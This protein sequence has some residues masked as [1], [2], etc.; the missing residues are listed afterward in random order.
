MF[1]LK[2]FSGIKYITKNGRRFNATRRLRCLDK[3]LGCQ[4]WDAVMVLD[5]TITGKTL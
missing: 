2:I 5:N 4:Q 3:N 1:F